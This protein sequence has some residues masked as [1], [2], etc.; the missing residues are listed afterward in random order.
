MNKIHVPDYETNVAI[1]P[2]FKCSCG[3][4]RAG[5]EGFTCHHNA[6]E[7]NHYEDPPAAWPEAGRLIIKL[8]RSTPYNRFYTPNC[9]HYAIQPTGM[10][11]A[12]R[13]DIDVAAQFMAETAI[14]AN[15]DRTVHLSD[16]WLNE[17]Y[18]EWQKR[19]GFSGQEIKRKNRL[20]WINREESI[21]MVG[22]ITVIPEE[23]VTAAL[24]YS[25]P[26]VAAQRLRENPRQPLVAPASWPKR[27]IRDLVMSS[28]AMRTQS[29][30]QELL[31]QAA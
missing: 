14:L 26:A 22:A 16:K 30:E 20:D 4:C 13:P 15:I 12:R 21:G 31:D 3:K 5:Q 27:L 23:V 8:F 28:E 7:K 17:K 9:T 11:R 24:V 1:P 19:I 25:A 2:E 10:E 6:F 29:E 18:V